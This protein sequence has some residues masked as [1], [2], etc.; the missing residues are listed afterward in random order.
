[1]Y[2]FFVF[3]FIAIVV[4]LAAKQ[5]SIRASLIGK[6]GERI[7]NNELSKLPEDYINLKDIIL[8]TEKGTSQIDHVVVSK[9]A[10]FTIET[11]HYRGQIYGSDYKEQWKQIIKTNVRYHR[12]WL[13]VYTYITKNTFYN[14]V[15]Q[16]QGHVVAIKKFLDLYPKVPIVPIV[17]FTGDVLLNNVYS[18]SPVLYTEELLAEIAKY[19]E[20]WLTQ[21]QVE[22]IAEALKDG[23]VSR[24]VSTRKHV[25]NIKR[26]ITEKENKNVGLYCPKCGSPLYVRSGKY[27]PFYGCSNYP[28]CK[29]T[30]P[31]KKRE[32]EDV[33]YE[34][35]I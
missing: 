23:D 31:I 11:K 1:M 12:N 17:V 32:V 25:R 7:V 22:Q 2:L 14:P 19:Q 10:I 33:E 15:K 21:S 35:T 5:K 6:Q 20:V 29:Y 13:K 27:G 9:Y 8:E 16:A 18:K 26:S 34:E 28:M 24:Q 4:T 3:I 30:T